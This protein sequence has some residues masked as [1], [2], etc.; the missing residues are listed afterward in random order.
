MSKEKRTLWTAIAIIIA[1]LSIY[2]VRANSGGITFE[3]TRQ[4][5]GQASP[6]WMTMAVLCMLGYLVF[7]AFALRFL[8]IGAGYRRPMVKNLLYSAGDVYFS[9]ITPSASGGQPAVAVLM[10]MDKVPGAVVTVILIANLVLYTSAIVVI[11]IFCLIVRARVFMHFRI[12]SRVLII[13]SLA[14]LIALTFLLYG[15]L[16]K[17]DILQKVGH[18]LIN[19]CTKIRLMRHP[20]KW[21]T[22][23]DKMVGDYQQC[24]SLLAGKKKII[25]AAFIFNLLQRVSQITV[26]LMVFFALPSLRAYEARSLSLWAVQAFAQV[27]SNVVPIPGGIGLADFLML[28]GF[29]SMFPREIAFQLGIISRALSFYTCAILSAVIALIGYAILAKRSGKTAD[30]AMAEA[31]G[32]TAEMAEDTNDA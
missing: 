20:E 25:F 15:L 8:L 1:I 12:I 22:K 29:T 23:L 18:G 16:R 30:E 4:L 9:A 3:E 7:E 17:G 14:V 32:E 31:Q 2:A 28:D 13:G 26:S 11:G 5:L 6:F 19:L 21:R 10:V 24:A 27:G